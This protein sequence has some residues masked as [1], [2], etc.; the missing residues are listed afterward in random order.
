MFICETLGRKIGYEPITA[1][2]I[3]LSGEVRQAKA[4]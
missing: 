1:E 4:G 2:A 3:V